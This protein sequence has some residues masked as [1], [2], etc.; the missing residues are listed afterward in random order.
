MPCGD[1][2]AFLEL[3]ARDAEAFGDCR[4]SEIQF[5][6]PVVDRAGQGDGSWPASEHGF[7]VN[8]SAH[9]ENVTRL[10]QFAKTSRTRTRRHS[11]ARRA[12]NRAGI[13]LAC[14]RGRP[15]NQLGNEENGL[16]GTA[17]IKKQVSHA[18]IAGAREQQRR[19]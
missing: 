2:L 9:R 7:K 11:Q 5:D 4:V 6:G 10:V 16:T 19:Q 8:F 17:A 3:D 18:E 12:Q 14:G 15:E 13:F 1:L